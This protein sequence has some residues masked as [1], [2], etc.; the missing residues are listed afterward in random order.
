MVAR[1]AAQ[2]AAVNERSRCLW[3]LERLV[4]QCSKDL[5]NKLLPA[6]QAQLVQLRFELTKTICKAART[7]IISGVRPPEKQ[8]TLT[9][10]PKPPATQVI[11]DEVAPPVPPEGS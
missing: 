1:R 9:P 11:I 4:Q 2:E 5:E 8:A 3:I 6:G 7:L 10:A